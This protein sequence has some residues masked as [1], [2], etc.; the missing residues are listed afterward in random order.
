MYKQTNRETNSLQQGND[1]TTEGS[2]MK[3]HKERERITS[4][5]LF[6]MR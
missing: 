3:E 4:N 2:C 5:V 1:T 6:Q